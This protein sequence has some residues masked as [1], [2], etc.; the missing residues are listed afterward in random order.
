MKDSGVSSIG[1]VPD[2]WEV[3]P[4]GRLGRLTKGR[5][6]SKDDTESEGVPCIR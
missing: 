1:A 5:G 6:G 2:H 4:I 3:L